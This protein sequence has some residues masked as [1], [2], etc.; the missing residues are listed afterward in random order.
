MDDK[1]KKDLEEEHDNAAASENRQGVEETKNPVDDN[2]AETVAPDALIKAQADLAEST[3]RYLRL[4]ADYANY[5]KRTAGEKLQLSEVV[6]G[7]VLKDVLPVLDNFERALQTPQEQMNDD[8]KSFLDGFEMIYKQLVSVL[9]KEGL[10][11]IDAVGKPFDPQFHEAVMRMPSDE[12]E[13]DTV[14]EVLQAG[15]ILGDKVVRPAMVKV[16]FNG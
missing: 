16:A 11:K 6:K 3:E 9:Q 12:Y 10:Q 15:Y 4:Q 13:D 5:K 2:N 8:I 7:E 1:E 14:I